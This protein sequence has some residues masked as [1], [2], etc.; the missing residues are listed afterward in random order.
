MTQ[1]RLSFQEAKQ[2]NTARADNKTRV[3]GVEEA[4][5]VPFTGL[6]KARGVSRKTKT[7]SYHVSNTASQTPA[8][9]ATRKCEAARQS[10]V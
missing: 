9:T 4:V 7:K 6:Q 5:W 1:N 8:S 10:G 3:A 2:Q